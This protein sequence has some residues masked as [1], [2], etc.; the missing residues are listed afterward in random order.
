MRTGKNGVRRVAA[1]VCSVALFA[2]L[3]PV[4]VLAADEATSEPLAAV[5]SLEESGEEKA[6]EQGE[7]GIQPETENACTKS[8][9]CVAET[10]E[11]GCPKYV[12]PA[13]EEDT[14]PVVSCTKSEDCVAETHEEGCPKYVAPAEEEDTDPV[15][16]CTK[17]EDCAAETHEEGCPKYVAPEEEGTASS[18]AD[19]AKSEGTPVDPQ[20]EK[21]QYAVMDL[22]EGE[23]EESSPLQLDVDTAE[24]FYALA[25]ILAAGKIADD[26]SPTEKQ[27]ADMTTLGFSD[28]KDAA[29]YNT[30]FDQVQTATLNI[31]GEISLEDNF[32]GIGT[33]A[34]LLP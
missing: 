8:E 29:A 23:M 18:S 14:D 34:T 3:L 17:S 11:E 30:A 28:V 33:M 13:E 4:Q 9:D 10:H 25:D 15:V 6:P 32:E 2:T 31:T 24:Q 21:T 20:E 7:T 1:L 26:P 19:N 22:E 12:A 27:Q 5:T 16:S